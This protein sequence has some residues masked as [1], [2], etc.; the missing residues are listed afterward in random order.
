M[1][2]IAFKDDWKSVFYLKSD[3]AFFIVFTKTSYQ[4]LTKEFC[5]KKKKM[6]VYTS[7]RKK[8]KFTLEV[9]TSLGINEF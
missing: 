6:K 3:K 5:S 8:D 9:E 7:K 1:E 4:W 2:Q